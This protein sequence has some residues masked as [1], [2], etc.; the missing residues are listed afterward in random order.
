MIERGEIPGVVRLGSRVLFRRIEV[1]Q[2]VGLPAASTTTAPA[3]ITP[4]LV[5]MPEAAALLGT[6]VQALKKN[7][8]R[9]QLPKGAV[10]RIGDRVKFN[11]AKLGG[12]Q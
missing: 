9:H 12:S 5:D 2:L 1:R 7:V 11:V 8:Q 10:V 6:S 3:K 4:I